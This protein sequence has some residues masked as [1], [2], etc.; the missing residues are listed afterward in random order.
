MRILITADPMIPVPPAGYGGIE[1]IVDALV[2]AY[3]DRGNEVALLA[4]P[5]SSSPADRRFSW[6]T[7][8]TRGLAPA[9]TNIR[10]MARAVS[11]FSP[12]IVHSFSRLAYMASILPRRI[13]KVMSYQRHTGGRQITWAAAI[14]RGSIQFTGCSE[15]IADLGRAAG[16]RWSAIHNFVEIEKITFAHEVPG[17]APLLFL[18]RIESIKGPDLAIQIAL[19]SRRRLQ[20]AGNRPT[21]GAELDFWRSKVEPYLGKDG[22]EWV[23]E[24]NDAQKDRLLCRAAALLAPIQWDEPFGIVYAE[25]LAAGTPIVTCRRGA[26]PEIV[27]D[28]VTGIFITGAADGQAAIGRL[29]QLDR[30]RCRASAITRFS[31]EVCA[32]HYLSLF[33]TMLK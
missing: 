24:V 2:R 29:A 33:E 17:D 31:R 9:M 3:R 27:E 28:G 26:A 15:Y 14:G 7:L 20:L 16:G 23:G 21:H 12:D 10:Q 6:K 1:R 11:E 18:G 30:G 5:D 32:G 19:A 4:H 13:P 8:E 25:A 22:I